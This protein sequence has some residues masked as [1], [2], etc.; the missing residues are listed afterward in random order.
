MYIWTRYGCVNQHISPSPRNHPK[1]TEIIL[2]N[3]FLAKLEDRYYPKLLNMCK[4]SPKKLRLERK[5]IG[6]DEEKEAQKKIFWIFIQ[7]FIEGQISF[8]KV[9]RYVQICKTILPIFK[10]RCNDGTKMDQR[11]IPS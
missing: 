6:E 9:K 11:E 2:K 10:S 3:I 4:N 7:K 1:A 8:L 5:Q